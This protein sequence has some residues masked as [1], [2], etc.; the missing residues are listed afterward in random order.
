MPP[1]KSSPFAEHMT[2]YQYSGAC[3]GQITL[4]PNKSSFLRANSTMSICS[5]GFN[6]WVVSGMFVRQFRASRDS[7]APAVRYCL[8]F[9][10]CQ[11]RAL[12]DSGAPAVRYCLFFLSVNLGPQRFW[13]PS[14]RVVSGLFVRQF[15]TL[16]DSWAPAVKYCLVSLSVN[17]RP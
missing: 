16:M 17:F 10:V 5:W 1:L 2:A 11:C 7:G 13:G 9:F 12:R 6:W 4:Q 3:G 8:V 15:R 14:W